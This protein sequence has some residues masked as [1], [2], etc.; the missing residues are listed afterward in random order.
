MIII[1]LLNF[2]TVAASHLYKIS[3]CTVHF[4]SRGPS[5]IGILTMSFFKQLNVHPLNLFICTTVTRWVSFI[6]LYSIPLL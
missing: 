6:G 1:A 4:T 2:T 5:F 3:S